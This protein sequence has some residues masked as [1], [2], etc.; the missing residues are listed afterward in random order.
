VEDVFDL[1]TRID[2]HRFACLL[3]ADDGAVALQRSDG[4]DL[5]EHREDVER[6]HALANG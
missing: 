3:I 1:I 5:V 2:D 4:K 6:E